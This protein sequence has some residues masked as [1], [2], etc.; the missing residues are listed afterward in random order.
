MNTTSSEPTSVP[1]CSRCTAAHV[2]R[3]G[4]NSVGTP[5]FRC[6]SCRHRFVANPRKGP[7]SEEKRDLIRR[8][9]LERLSLRAI[10]RVV[11][12]SRSWLQRFVNTLYAQTPWEPGDL[13][14]KDGQVRLEVDELWSFIGRKREPWWVWTALDS[15][16][17][18]VVGMAV[19]ERDE[20]TARC[21]WESL[22]PAYRQ[23]TIVATDLLPVYQAVV[24]EQ[25]HTTGGKE[26]G[27]TAH[28]E[29]FFGTLRQRC[30]RV[31]R[32]T[33]SFSR[34]MENHVGALWYFIRHYNQCRA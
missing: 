16:T 19:G 3:N 13:K 7:V 22:P 29:R 10:V 25:W 6:R 24:P 15:R 21:L 12:V 28:I 32:K 1:T 33:L 11:G 5:T 4:V 9:L 8:L 23:R 27:L 31:V 26:R 2:V 14:K 20:F 34:K 17:R 18:Q 30:A